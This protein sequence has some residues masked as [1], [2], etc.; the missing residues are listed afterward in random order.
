MN[1][2]LGDMAV[3]RLGYGAMRV[4][5]P[6]VWGEPKD[7]PGALRLFRRAVELG[8]NFFDTAES[9]GPQT[10]EVL[11]AEALHPYP[12]GFVIGTKG[13]LL[14]PSPG[15]WDSDARP[16]KLKKD[17]DGSLKRLRLERIDLYQLHAPDPKVPLEDSLGAIV[18]AQKAGKVR[19]IG[20]SNVNAKELERARRVANIVSVQ[21]RYSIGDRNSEDVLKACEKLGIAFLPWYPLGAGSALTNKKILSISKKINATPVQVAIAWLLAK[22]PVML[23]IPG[24]SSIAHLEE[25]MKAA[26]LTLSAE[27]LALLG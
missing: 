20:V 18:D 5:G 24:T 7:R 26:S 14:R 23:P 27:D 8:V 12:A 1:L 16:E 3:H 22:S 4:L 19:H 10:D 15:R 2:R 9:Y 25:N 13:G 6:N 17:L 21:N 11:I